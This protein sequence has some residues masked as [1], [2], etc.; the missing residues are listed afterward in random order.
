M[1]PVTATAS[2]S[3]ADAAWAGEEASNY[4]GWALDGAGDLDADGYADLAVGAYLNDAGG[5]DAGGVYVILGATATGGSLTTTSLHLTGESDTRAGY[6][7]ASAGDTDGDG[8]SDLLIGAP[9]YGGSTYRYG[10]AYLVAGPITS[11][12]T[13]GAA[14]VRLRGDSASDALGCA[15]GHVDADGD[16]RDDLLV[17]AYGDDDGGTD[18]GAVYV[19]SGLVSGSVTIASVQSAKITASSSYGSMGYAMDGGDVDGDGWE[20]ILV[21]DHQARPDGTDSGAAYL[22]YGPVAGTLGA[23]M[24]DVTWSGEDSSDTLGRSVAF[25]GDIDGDG[26]GDVLL[27]APGEDTTVA[28]GAVYVLPFA[29]LP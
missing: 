21:G 6:A 26:M 9:Y 25:G 7:V 18:A 11:D 4:A 8:L 29:G 13:L 17:G 20:D 28:A 12:M 27:G 10:A 24:A 19:V 2:L 22:C 14:D 23:A 16:G 1:A 3:T 5:T 15:V